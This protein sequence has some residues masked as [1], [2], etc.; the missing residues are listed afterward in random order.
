MFKD[1]VGLRKHLLSHAPKVHVCAECGKAFKEAS[2]L[3]R[4]QL[5]HT[6][7][8]PFQVHY[9]GGFVESNVLSDVFCPLCFVRCLN[10]QRLSCLMFDLTTSTSV[11]LTT[12]VVFNRA[13]LTKSSAD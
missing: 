1:H 5:V 4:H 7:E 9:I 12:S 10:H 13:L 2:K 8:K 6:G 11:V 3:K